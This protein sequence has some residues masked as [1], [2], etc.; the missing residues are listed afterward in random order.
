MAYWLFKSEPAT[1]SWA[2]QVEA[3]ATGTHWNGVRNHLAKKHLMAMQVGE[4]GFFYHSNEGKAVVGIVEV[5]RPYYPDHTDA[6]G[7]FGMVDV[8]AVE[9]LPRPVTLDAIKA[10]PA[11]AAMVLVNNSRLSVQPVTEA[12]WNRIRALAETP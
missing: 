10:D 12:E 6:T 7:R 11:L 4:Q 9:P 8:K 2:Q 3:G 1:W 5:I